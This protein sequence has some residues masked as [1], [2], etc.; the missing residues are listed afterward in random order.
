MIR[1][2]DWGC[3]YENTKNYNGE[4]ECG[5]GRA[6][7]ELCEK[8]NIK[9]KLISIFT[10]HENKFGKIGTEEAWFLIQ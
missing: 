2:D 6:H 3:F 5:E 10:S 7:K 8:Y 1:Y 4:F 9:T